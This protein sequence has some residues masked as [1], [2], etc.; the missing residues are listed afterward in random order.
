MTKLLGRKGVMTVTLSPRPSRS[1][2][3]S[4]QAD[5]LL[6]ALPLPARQHLRRVP[7][8]Q[9]QRCRA[10]RG[11]ILGGAGVLIKSGLLGKFWKVIVAGVVGLGAHLARLLG[12]KRT[13]ASRRRPDRR[14]SS[15]R[16]ALLY[17]W[18]GLLFGIQ[19]AC[20]PP[21]RGGFRTR[22]LTGPAAAAASR[23]RRAARRTTALPHRRA[24][25]GERRRVASLRTRMDDVPRALVD[26]LDHVAAKRSTPRV[27]GRPSHAQLAEHAEAGAA[28]LVALAARPRIASRRSARGRGRRRRAGQ[29]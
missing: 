26:Q 13:R 29:R 23:A 28:R 24:E 22:R 12:R 8:G 2:T 20:S 7:A 21:A 6:G 4:A 5:G 3:A 19:R 17:L 27:G 9:G 10:G 11:L 14:V 18:E 1:P 15:R 16:P 25:R